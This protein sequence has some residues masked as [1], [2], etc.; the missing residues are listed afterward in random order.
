PNIGIRGVNSD[1]SA[2]VTLLEDGIPLAPAPYAAPAAYY[3]PMATRMTA[4]EIFKGAAATQYGPQTVAGAINLMTRDVPTET[5]WEID[6]AGGMRTTGR[7]HAFVGDG[8]R[9][10]GW[11][12]EGVHL[13]TAGFKE[14]DT[15]GP[16]GFNRT[17]L[18]AK[19]RMAAGDAHRLG[20]KLGYSRELSNETYT[21]L[22]PSDFEETPYRRY[23]ATALGQMDWNRTQAEASW[24]VTPSTD[25]NIRTVAYHHWMERSW[26]KL[27]RFGSGIDAH[28]L[29]QQDPQTGQGAVYMGILRGEENTTSADQALF[30]GTNDRRFHSYGAQ[31]SLRWVGRMGDVRHT[32]NSGVRLH[33]DHVIRDH[34]EE[35][36]DMTNGRLVRNDT[37][38]VTTLDSVATAYALSAHVHEDLRWKMLHLLPGL[39]TEIIRT[40]RID[41]GTPA[42]DPI[43]RTILLPGVGGMVDLTPSWSVF[44]GSYRGFSPVPPG[45]EEDVQPEKSWNH[46]AGTRVAFADLQV[47][48]VG[49]LNEYS[50]LTGQCTMSSGC[51]ND[52]LGAQY[53]GGQA[54]VRGLEGSLKHVFLLPG[55]FSMPLQGSYTY[56]EGQFRT[57]FSSSFPQFGDVTAGDYLPYV[58]KQ[59]AYGRLTVAHTLFDLGVGVAYRSEMLDV[60]GQYPASDLDIPELVLIDGGVRVMPVE[61]VTVYAT[62]TNLANKAAITAWRPL[63]ARPVAPRQVMVGVEVRSR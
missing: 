39:R 15:G 38:M 33:G 41:K 20:L 50:N 53:N 30:I 18:M 9:S 42:L 40:E 36:H 12:V 54:R 24:A 27:N 56:T 31:T 5:T 26:F 47:D 35:G 61:R 1:R 19:G 29:L 48:F 25:L 13:Q 55:A 3:F 43:T 22:T 63:G 14:L 51:N 60:A 58:P 6:L 49:F 4:V 37:E 2:K 7:I 45:E 21:G 44:G 46:E 23:A 28:G 34:T 16:T 11:L 10:R 32:L 52:D 57:S 62:G 59:Q 8:N 17:E